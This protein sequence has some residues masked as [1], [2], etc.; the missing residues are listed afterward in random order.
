MKAWL[1]SLINTLPSAVSIVNTIINSRSKS[2][3]F[4]Q[5]WEN[6]RAPV[7]ESNYQEDMILI[8]KHGGCYLDLASE[9]RALVSNAANDT[10]VTYACLPNES[11]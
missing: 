3:Q 1:S 5:R 4:P 10:R 9:S 2:A 6:I 8:C 7:Y 11:G